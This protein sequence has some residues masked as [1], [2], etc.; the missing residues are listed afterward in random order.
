[1]TLIGKWQR[2]VVSR[3]MQAAPE[4]NLRM[5]LLLSG[6]GDVASTILSQCWQIETGSVATSYI[7][8]S[9]TLGIRAQDNLVN[10]DP[11]AIPAG[12]TA[13][14]ILDVVASTIPAATIAWI[15]V[16]LSIPVK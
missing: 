10:L 2:L 4:R 12:F 16:A 13:S 5:S 1:M 7:P 14:D 15:S 11:V 8:T 3:P 9:G 6:S